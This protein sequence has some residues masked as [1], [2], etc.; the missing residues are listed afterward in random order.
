MKTGSDSGLFSLK[1]RRVLGDLIPAFQYQRG[2]RRKLEKDFLQGNIVIGQ[3]KMVLDL[4][5]VDLG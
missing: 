3:E 2:P 4:K 1:N 5:T